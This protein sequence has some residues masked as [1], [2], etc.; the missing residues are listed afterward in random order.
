MTRSFIFA[1]KKSKTKKRIKKKTKFPSKSH[2]K[3]TKYAPLEQLKVSSQFHF[4]VYMIVLIIFFKYYR[5]KI[6][7]IKPKLESDKFI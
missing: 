1:L 4:V 6:T 3:I 7:T 2:K 5:S